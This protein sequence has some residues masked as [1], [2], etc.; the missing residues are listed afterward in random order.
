[1]PALHLA[2]SLYNVAVHQE[3]RVPVGSHK[4][5]VPDTTVPKEHFFEQ[6]KL[7]G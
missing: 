2:F 4:F 5:V 1:M 3:L 6:W 7:Y